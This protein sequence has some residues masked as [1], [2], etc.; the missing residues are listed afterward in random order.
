M[1]QFTKAEYGI[2]DK[3]IYNIDENG[4]IIDIASSSKV[5]FSNT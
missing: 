1:Y 4:Y 5:L 3:D 2:F